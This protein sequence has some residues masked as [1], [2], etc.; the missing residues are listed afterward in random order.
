MHEKDRKHFAKFD[1]GN[2]PSYCNNNDSIFYIFVFPFY[3]LSWIWPETVLS[4][5]SGT[6]FSC[7]HGN[8]LQLKI[9]IYCGEAHESGLKN[10]EL[11]VENDGFV[12]S[13]IE[14]KFI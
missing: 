6:R 12:D 5:R 14:E 1:S 11:L 3:Q 4:V 9:L 10:E 8:L 2:S 13:W 7:S